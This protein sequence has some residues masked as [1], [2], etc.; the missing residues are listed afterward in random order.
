MKKCPFCAEEIQDEAIV[1]RYCRRD[2]PPPRV[3]GVQDYPVISIPVAALEREAHHANNKPTHESFQRGRYIWKPA[4]VFGA[5]MSA[6]AA[7]S[8]LTTESGPELWGDLT[9]GLVVTFCFWTIVGAVMA[10]LWHATP[11]G[12][13]SRQ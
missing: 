7:V 4:M 13:R 2:L 3:D 9:F 11:W 8:F 12:K 6:I 10:A 1:C 5:I